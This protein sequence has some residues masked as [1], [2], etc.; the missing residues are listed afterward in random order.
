MVKGVLGS[1]IGWNDHAGID[2]LVGVQHGLHTLGA[3]FQDEDR[4]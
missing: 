4:G 2:V 3:Y 1:D